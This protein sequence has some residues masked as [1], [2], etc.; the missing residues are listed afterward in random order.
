VRTGLTS[1]NPTPIST[2]S[3]CFCPQRGCHSRDRRRPVGGEGQR[4]P[5]RS[6]VRLLPSFLLLF[7]PLPHF[8]SLAPCEIQRVAWLSMATRRRVAAPPRVLSPASALPTSAHSPSS[9]CAMVPL[10]PKPHGGDGPT[11]AWLALSVRSTRAYA[12][13]ATVVTVV[14]PAAE[15]GPTVGSSPTRIFASLLFRSRVRVS[16]L[17]YKPI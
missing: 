7:L 8:P 13:P 2:S 3:L 12:T 16:V 5:A 6:H 11:S 9:G 15:V 14:V 1:M 4:R 10:W 17:H